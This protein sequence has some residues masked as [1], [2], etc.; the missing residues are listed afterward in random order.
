MIIERNGNFFKM[1]ILTFN[2]Y[3]IGL[4]TKVFSFWY[5]VNLCNQFLNVVHIIKSLE[6]NFQLKKQK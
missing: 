5:C 6:M 1:V 2:I 3:S 4:N